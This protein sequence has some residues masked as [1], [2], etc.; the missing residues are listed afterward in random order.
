[1]QNLVGPIKFELKYIYFLMNYSFHIRIL[2]HPFDGVYIIKVKKSTR[3]YLALQHYL[4]ATAT[5]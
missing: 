1:M 3:L 4:E 2:S 5:S